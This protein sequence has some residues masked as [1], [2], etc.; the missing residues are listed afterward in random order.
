MEH[1]DL[2]EQHEER[3]KVERVILVTP[4][5]PGS[6]GDEGMLLGALRILNSV[7]VHLL[8]PETGPLWTDVL[9]KSDDMSFVTEHQGAFA[10]FLPSIRPTDAV[11]VVG[12]DVIDGTC[13][14]GPALVRLSFLKEAL[15]R[16]ARGAIAC[17]FRSGVDPA[18]VDCLKDLPDSSVFL[19]DVKSLENFSTQV[20][21]RAEFF[22]D[23]SY[24]A[25]PSELQSRSCDPDLVAWISGIH[26]RG[27][28]VIGLNFSEQMFRSLSDNHDN[29]ARSSLVTNVINEILK[30]VPDACFVL[31]SNDNRD[32][33][34]HL[35]DVAYQ[36]FAAESLKDIVGIDGFRIQDPSRSYLDNIVLMGFLDLLVTGRMHLAHA[37]VRQGTIPLIMMG[38]GRG[39]TSTDKMRGMY[40]T[41]FETDSGVV[42]EI[43]GLGAAI[44]WA[45][46]RMP[47]LK[48]RLGKWNK[49]SRFEEEV[50][51][52]MLVRS[53]GLSKEPSSGGEMLVASL[54]KRDAETRLTLKHCEP[55]VEIEPAQAATEIQIL[56]E[57][58]DRLRVATDL[59][60]TEGDR[61]AHELFRAYRRPWKPIRRTIQ[62]GFLKL[63]LVF[64]PLLS[65]RTADRFRRSIQKR[66]PSLILSQ[67]TE[68]KA[69]VGSSVSL[70][71][72]IASGRAKAGLSKVVKYRLLRLL[73]KLAWPFSRRQAEKFRRSADKRNPWRFD[74]SVAVAPPAALQ[75]VDM[76]D[77]PR[78]S[79]IF[80]AD[81]RLPRADTS[82]GE[83]ATVGLISDLCAVGYE[84]VFA[85]T[86]MNATSPYLEELQG[87]GVEV[88]TRESGYTYTSDYIREKGKQFGAFYFIRVDVAEDLIAAAR[89]AAPEARI[90][91][92]APDLYS[93]REN[94]AAGLSGDPAEKR[95]AEKTR[96]R[97]TAIMRASD[98]VVLVSP[99][100]VPYVKDIVSID[101]ISV[102]PAL[103]SSIVPNPPGYRE[104]QNLFFI[105]GFAHTPNV[106][107][108]KWFVDE[109]WPAIHA[110]LPEAE[111]HIIG[112]EAPEDIVKLGER[113]GVS[114]VGYVPDLAP[115][116]ATY[117][118]SV[119]PLLYGAGIKGKLGTAMGAGVPS[120]VTTIAAEG[121]N[122]VDGAHA[123]VRDEPILFA[124]AVIRLYQ[125]ENLWERI[126][127]GGRALVE[128]NFGD[129]ANQASFL[130]LLDRAGVLPLDLY[131]KYCQDVSSSRFPGLDPEQVVD[132]SIVIP[133]HNQWTLTKAC[134]SSVLHACRGTGIDCEV[135]LADDASTDD[136]LRAAEFFP[137]LKIVRQD[138]N[139]GF[140]GNCNAA[141]AGA[142]GRYLLFLNNDTVVMPNW[143]T[144]LMAAATRYPDAAILGSKLI[145]PD[146]TIQ[147]AGSVLFADGSAANLGRG[148]NRYDPR[149][150][151]DR[152]V[153]YATG[154]SI[155]VVRAFWDDVGGFDERYI[156][157]Y[158]E[159]SDLAMAARAHGLHVT[160]IPS[161]EVVH[162]EHGSYG[163]QASVTPQ[164]YQIENGKK[165]FDKWSTQFAR[166][167][168]PASVLQDAEAI[169]A[170]RRSSRETREQRRQKKLNI[171]YFSPFPSHPNNHGNQVR[172]QSLGRHF[173]QLG[174]K[175]HFVLLESGM[176]NENAIKF[177]RSTWDTFDLLQN[178]RSLESDGN[179]IPFD[180]W[181]QEGL[182]EEIAALCRKYDI[183]LVLCSYVFQSKLLEYV[184]AHILKVIDT[185]DKMGGRYE[186]LRENGQPLE[187]FSCSPQ[188]E[189]EYLRR[190]DV[191]VAMR[192]EEASYF[193]DVSGR[194]TSIV[195]PHIERR[196][197]IDRNFS[198]IE[199]VGVV[200]SP[201]RINLAVVSELVK[202]LV[203]REQHAPIPF[204]L[205]I[206]GQIR[207]MVR[208][209]PS[210]EQEWFDRPWIK[211]HGF[212]P[213]IGEFYRA[214]DVVISPV[215]MGTG[216]NIKTVEALAYGMPLLST[217]WGSKGI[218]TSEPMHLHANL[219]SL[220][221]SLFDICR[222]P[223]RLQQL[224]VA[225]R[226][227]YEKFY[228]D[229]VRSIDL[230][231]RKVRA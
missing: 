161:S 48:T 92:H 14:P 160:Y 212:V 104:R 155:L 197:F 115:V 113:P 49:I 208:S 124:E 163:A 12:A 206:A 70:Q 97:E 196:R 152:D 177:M 185:H 5:A 43:E 107:A 67:W 147:D 145:Y 37:A 223:L 108:V 4:A 135:I 174:H 95:T 62:R 85:P 16:G 151:F 139:L 100:E 93:L 199:N 205:H 46:E 198:R 186:M 94:R 229:T 2:T 132:V 52:P 231:M 1:L 6:K 25:A 111:F 60:M 121:M 125:D 162:F 133:V 134:L 230:L 74:P 83:R 64:R 71:T 15:V 88:I 30:T 117:R 57:E 191:V 146:G 157:A 59:L 77:A 126:A 66:K 187:F 138:Q 84:V 211:L 102:F 116:L 188:E 228:N 153:D 148:Q 182:G 120:V 184:P 215:T 109:I 82:A 18:I 136:T 90:I 226:T 167:H 78:A 81:Y 55:S 220:S 87:L 119:V 69:Y 180:H 200:A 166:D 209:L 76:M 20:D 170:E 156:P 144:A 172:I 68:F 72:S 127:R 179:P 204:T 32:W 101:K 175:V 44:R 140:L 143:L 176:V 129:A 218:E 19:R 17:S 22:P 154:A 33:P 192:A 98:H 45:E 183:D 210:R 164:A 56:T 225:S 61:L 112:A 7:P 13:G 114:F 131:V 130:R 53:L 36:E 42:N 158:C 221:K 8:N 11:F 216:I 26:E 75:S 227:T 137:G 79:R 159:D 122:V 190:A 41:V 47:D 38:T 171:L 35:S 29:A 189:G 224:A 96:A 173:K 80:V 194:A 106:G 34:N 28:K 54:R 214:M 103:Y 169:H 195:I 141:A 21:S 9:S 128:D 58:R 118:L 86:D 165:L 89:E 3:P 217:A 65:E 168:L 203:T 105:G 73:S 181:Y 201:N 110:A 40:E 91:F 207:E 222:N 178:S 142:R 27:G 39:Y 50:L 51:R 23:L 193:D 24:F 99:A 31:I 10:D 202:T 149:F 213:D 63:I 219:D 150:C 123:L